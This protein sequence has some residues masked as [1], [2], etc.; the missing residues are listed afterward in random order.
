MAAFRPRLKSRSSWPCP[1]A[2]AG[3]EWADKLLKR[4]QFADRWTVFFGDMF[5]IRSDSEGGA[6]LLALAHRAVDKG[7][8]YDAMCRQLLSASGKAGLTPEVGFILGDGADP[9]AMA[10]VTA[11]V[12]MGV[13]IACAQCHNHPFDVWKRKQFYD[14]AAYFGK[15][16]R[17][18]HRIKD[19]LL[20]VSLNE[21]AET[22][23][24]WPPE[25]KAQGKPRTAVKAS[26]PFPLDEGDGPNKHIARLKELRARQ[27]AEAKAAKKGNTVD[28]LL[29][30]AESK[31][32][33][34]TGKD[35][36]D[37]ATEA[38]LAA[39][40]LNVD[41]DIYKASVLRTEL[42]RLVTDPRNRQFSAQPGQPR[43]GRAARPGLC[44]PAG[45]LPRG[46]PAQPSQ[47]ARLP[48]R[49]VRRQRLRLALAGADDRRDQGLPAGPPADV[50]GR[51]RPP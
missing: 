27:E 19:R 5:R 23:I 48:G 11:Q 30:E 24:L 33:P 6:E 29:N 16:R 25:D 2:H 14:L 32:D 4:E 50:G 40:N 37:V 34:K 21:M 13:R 9:M 51:H 20:G 28:D 43:L 12:F 8:P 7:L 15:T 35:E 46:Q 41:K 1:P 31:L 3:A 10:G 42:A 39:K 26:F 47:D 36:F 22:T 17:V 49:R 45:R 44:Q 18:E 38:K